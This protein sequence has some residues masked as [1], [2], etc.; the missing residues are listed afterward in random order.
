MYICFRFR[1]AECPIRLFPHAQTKEIRLCNDEVEVLVVDLRYVLC[2]V[3]CGYLSSK[4][5]EQRSRHGGD[6]VDV[7]RAIQTF[8][9]V[10]AYELYVGQSRLNEV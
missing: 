10:G 5:F 2:G 1:A 9:Q 3:C 7:C 8:G 6:E 4:I